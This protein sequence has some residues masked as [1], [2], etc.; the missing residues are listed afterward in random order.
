M[1]SRNIRQDSNPAFDFRVPDDDVRV[2]LQT[3]VLASGQQPDTFLKVVK[4][5]KAHFRMRPRPATV[6]GKFL[7]LEADECL[8]SETLKEGAYQ[9]FERFEYSEDEK[10]WEFSYLAWKISR[11]PDGLGNIL[12]V[13]CGSGSELI[14]LRS[15]Y[16]IAQITAIDYIQYLKCGEAEIDALKVNFIE[17]D[18]F[19][20]LETL[21]Q[22]FDLVFSN[23]VIEH[24][25]E[26]DEQLSKLVSVIRPGG[27][28]AAALP[29]DS[30]LH[31]DH[32]QA[33]ASCPSSIIPLDIGWMDLRHPWKTN[34]TDL[35]GTMAQS[36]MSQITIVQ[37][38]AHACTHHAVSLEDIRRVERRAERLYRLLLAP[39][40]VVLTLS[41]VAPRLTARLFFSLDRRMWFG[42][43]RLKTEY[44]PEVFVTAIK[45]F[46]S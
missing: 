17:G 11:L 23:H 40:R 24:F 18:I 27:L 14:L 29:L 8:P 13:G 30:S 3:Q 20:T 1:R 42:R 22:T 45:P 2:Y 12:V 35:A 39:V 43:Y 25:Y 21:P 28:F 19:R 6:T 31:T 37:R 7:E 4:L 36:G 44:Q 33:R 26:P 41:R 9:W 15:K 16:P 10:S 32:F 46:S 38:R 34:E 5:A